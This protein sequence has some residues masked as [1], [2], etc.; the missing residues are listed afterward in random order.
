MPTVECPWCAAPLE[1][2]L[3]TA[4]EIACDTCLIH[5]ELAPDPAPIL[6]AAA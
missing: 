2:D 6:A 3:S 5:V 4:T 1:A